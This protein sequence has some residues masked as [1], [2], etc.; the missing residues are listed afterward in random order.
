MSEAEL[1]KQLLAAGGAASP[2]RTA[3]GPVIELIGATYDLHSLAV[4][5]F[6]QLSKSV[7]PGV[8]IVEHVRQA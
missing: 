5:D 8:P 3:H 1:G 7:W 6:A 4:A 2:S